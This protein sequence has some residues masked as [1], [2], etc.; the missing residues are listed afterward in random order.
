[1]FVAAPLPWLR[2]SEQT[3]RNTEEPTWDN[4]KIFQ[5]HCPY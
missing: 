3:I 4:S 2:K 1:M 5:P